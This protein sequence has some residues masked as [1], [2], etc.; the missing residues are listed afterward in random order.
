MRA[1]LD[2]EVGSSIEII[3]QCG[4]I[5]IKVF[6]TIHMK[7]NIRGCMTIKYNDI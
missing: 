4:Y 1:A 7:F 6:G 3:Y 2:L 5:M